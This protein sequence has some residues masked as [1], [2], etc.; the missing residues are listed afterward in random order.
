[1][2]RL[3]VVTLAVL[4]S[5]C[6][7]VMPVAKYT[8]MGCQAIVNSGVCGMLVR[9]GA[10]HRPATVPDCLDGETVVIRNW[11]DVQEKGARPILGCAKER[12]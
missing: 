10:E 9:A 1:M 4:A 7:H 2:K 8:C 5:G 12:K 3:A 6:A 11:P